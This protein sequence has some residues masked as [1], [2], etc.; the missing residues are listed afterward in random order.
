ME[1]K[2]TDLDF[3]KSKE[4]CHGCEDDFY[5]GN[6]DLGVKECWNFKS[7]FMKRTRKIPVSMRPPWTSIPLVPRLSCFRQTGFVFWEN[8]R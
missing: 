6:N 1:K 4:K 5:N 3:M 8:E 7:A 2:P